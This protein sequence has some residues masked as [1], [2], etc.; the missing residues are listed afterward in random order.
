MVRTTVIATRSN[1]VTTIVP[2]LPSHALATWQYMRRTRPC[3]RQ[4][5]TNLC[6]ETRAHSLWLRW[7]AGR[8]VK[9]P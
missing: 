7:A 9:P 3:L 2:A 1:I 6:S 8:A 5:C 4:L